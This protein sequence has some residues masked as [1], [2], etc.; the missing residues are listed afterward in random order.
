MKF[1]AKQVCFLVILVLM[2]IVSSSAWAQK[3]ASSA[4]LD[5]RLNNK[6]ITINQGQRTNL[7][8]V[9]KPQSIETGIDCGM[10]D[11]CGVDPCLCG[12]A[13]AWGYCSCNGLKKI[14]PTIKA[15]AADPGIIDVNVQNGQI[16]V[17]GIKPG[18]STVKITVGLMHFAG[19]SRM[20]SVKVLANKNKEWVLAAVVL[21][22][23][24][25]FLSIMFFWNRREKK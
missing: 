6:M 1:T 16:L 20:V 13:D 19:A 8:F 24:M 12:S 21:L 23:L 18:T 5:V 22:V 4:Q 10:P 17:R 3:S 9:I 11:M 2:L 14:L 15:T 7:G 25:F